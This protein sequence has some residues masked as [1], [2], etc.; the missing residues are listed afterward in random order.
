MKVRTARIKVLLA[1]LVILVSAVPATLLDTGDAAECQPECD[2]CHYAHDRV[3]HAYLDITRFTVPFSLNGTDQKQVEVQIRLHGNVGLGYTTIRRGHLTLTAANQYVGIKEPY[4]EFISMGPGFRSFYWNVSGRVEGTDTLHVEVWALGV[5]LAVEFFESADSGS[6]VVTNPVNAPP[7]VT[8]L[9]PDGYDDVATNDYTVRLDIDDPNADPMIADFYYDTDRDRSNGQTLIVR[10]ATSPETYLWN[11]RGIPNG[12]YYI[13]VDVDDQRSGT[14]SSTSTHPVIV[15]HSNNVPNTELVTPL[16]DGVIRDPM[17]TLTWRSEDRDGDSLSYEVWMGRDRD[18]ME[19]VGTTT[20]TSFEYAPV[21]NAKMAWIVVPN[22]GTV[23]G[24]CRNGPR[25]F[26]T[27]ISFPV[28]IELLLP[29][30][31]AVVMGPD[32]K[33]VW[34]GRDLDFEQVLYNVYIRHDGQTTRVARDWDDPAGPVLV[35]HGLEA[36]ETYTWWVDGDNPYSPKGVSQEWDFTIARSGSPVVDLDGET[37]SEGT[38]V[39]NWSPSF[40][41]TFPVQY[42]VHVV[43]PERGDVTLLLGTSATTTTLRDLV[44]DAV[45]HWYVIPFDADGNQGHSAPAFRTFTYDL[46]SPP[47]V[48]ITHPV[49]QVEPGPHALEWSARDPDG[50]AV[51]FD[52][53]MDP[54]NGTTLLAADTSATSLQVRVEADRIYRWRVVPRDATQVGEAATGIIITDPEGTMV[55]A[56]GNLSFPQDDGAVEPPIVNLSWEASD[57]LGRPILYTVYVNTSGGD[58][59]DGPPMAINSTLPWWTIEVEAGTTVSWAVKARPILGPSVLLGVA[60]FTVALGA[61]DVPTAVLRVGDGTSGA[62]VTLDALV[63]VAFNAS[64]SSYTGGGP[65]EYWFD[66]GD[67]R[68]S[69][70]QNLTWTEHTYLVGGRYNATLVVRTEDGI[71]S[72]P[73]LVRVEVGPGDKGSE[74]SVPGPG[75]VLTCIVLLAAAMTST[76]AHR[77]RARRHPRGGDEG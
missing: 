61:L 31:G 53:H 1:A 63:T 5:H 20:E 71:E 24:W 68:S 19:L 55:G 65:L 58:P 23:R 64:G 22:D 41:G 75:A 35:V 67:G 59:L 14:D 76:L 39:L 9:Q 33:L 48:T 60:T 12:W 2:H 40:E 47:E 70:W 74:D 42:D 72:D 57:P 38:V 30:D 15:S 37:V 16:D 56:V 73:A 50:D 46:N 26:T 43:D 11:T 62:P 6:I 18:R 8:F 7:I 36:G 10:G 77:Q 66:F 32:V 3:Y 17:T 44:E 28:E 54:W 45:Y 25:T 21:D 34:Y 52:V 69:G 51:T 13:H 49:V 29:A 4:K 27:D